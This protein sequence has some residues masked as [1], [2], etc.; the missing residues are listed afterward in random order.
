MPCAS[1]T[2]CIEC[3]ISFS[4][5]VLRISPQRLISFMRD[6]YAKKLLLIFSS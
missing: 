4:G 2:T 3:S 6:I 1:M 5:C